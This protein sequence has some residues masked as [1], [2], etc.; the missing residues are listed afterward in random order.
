MEIRNLITFKKILELGSFSNAADALGYSQS[1]ITMQMKQLE[2]ELNIQLFDR[3]GRKI[4]VNNEGLR[5]SK[6]ATNIINESQNAIADLTSDSIPKGELRIGILESICTAH[7]PNMLNKYHILYPNV[8][9]IIKIGTFTELSN[10]LNSGQ[11]DILWTFDNKIQTLEWINAFIYESPI[12]I[13]C[14]PSHP[15]AK[16]KELT[17]ADLVD[18][19]FIL[20][21][22]ECSYRIDF[23]N[24]LLSLGFSPNV[25]LEIGST[26]IIKKFVE[27]NLGLSV[28]PRYTVEKELESHELLPLTVT[29]FHIR[30]YG[31]LFYHKNKWL[32]PVLKCFIELATTLNENR[33]D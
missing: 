28:L 27:A 11:I 15:L 25:I 24:I 14:S 3:I 32:S 18:E 10:M 30:M 4:S 1:T 7:L 13:V 16:Q 33:T 26:E 21:E 12:I 23:T 19:P 22:K 8:K 9:T 17:L 2:S 29:D 6:Y 5:F 31:Q 20:T